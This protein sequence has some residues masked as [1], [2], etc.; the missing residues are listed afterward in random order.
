MQDYHFYLMARW[1]LQVDHRALQ[2]NRLSLRVSFGHLW[3]R[4]LVLHELAYRIL[5]LTVFALT[6]IRGHL[7]ALVVCSLHPNL[8]TLIL[9]LKNMQIIYFLLMLH[10]LS[11]FFGLILSKFEIV[12]MMASRILLRCL[13]L[14]AIL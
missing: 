5:L 12:F 9:L 13:R 4:W 10:F 8:L 7:C 1:A 3:L 14:H 11:L 6:G 2:A